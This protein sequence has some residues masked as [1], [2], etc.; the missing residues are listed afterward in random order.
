MRGSSPTGAGFIWRNE[1]SKRAKSFGLLLASLRIRAI[2][3]LWNNRYG[4]PDLNSATAVSTIL[5]A[6]RFGSLTSRARALSKGNRIPREGTYRL[7]KPSGAATAVRYW[8][9]H[10]PFG[11]RSAPKCDGVAARLSL[12]RNQMYQHIST[13][14]QRC[15]QFQRLSEDF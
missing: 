3:G 6:D 13:M 2:A 15:K 10:R 7:P 12:M 14:R 4:G 8:R 11:T 1:F 5:L 9:S